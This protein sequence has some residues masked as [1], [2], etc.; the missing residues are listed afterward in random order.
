[1]LGPWVEKYRP[2]TLDDIVGQK[3]IVESL[4]KYVDQGSMPNLMFTAAIRYFL[5]VVFALS[6]WPMSFKFLNKTEHKFRS[7][8]N[9]EC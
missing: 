4:K 7:L 8:K 3:Q 9:A 2:Q 1:M 6:I 5:I